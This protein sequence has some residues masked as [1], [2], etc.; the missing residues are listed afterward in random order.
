M[1]K[2]TGYENVEIDAGQIKIVKILLRQW[3]RER[4]VEI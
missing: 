1:R 2:I 3:L 4:H